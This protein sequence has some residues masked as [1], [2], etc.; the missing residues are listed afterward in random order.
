MDRPEQGR[1][2]L[3]EETDHHAGTREILRVRP[4]PTPAES[5]SRSPPVTQHQLTDPGP[6][7]SLWRALLRVSGVGQLSMVPQSGGDQEIKGVT[8]VTRVPQLLVCLVKDHPCKHRDQ[9]QGE[10]Q[11]QG[12]DQGHGQDEDQDQ[13]TSL[14]S[15]PRSQNLPKLVPSQEV[16]D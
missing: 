7:P 14:V 16:R 13:L 4:V 9:D 15:P 2:G 5:R 6:E 1:E 10:D 3:V 11:S 12:Q 8:M